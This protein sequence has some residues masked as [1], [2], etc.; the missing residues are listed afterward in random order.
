[1]LL[2]RV[3]RQWIRGRL[4]I[5]P[6]FK[7]IDLKWTFLNVSCHPF[8]STKFCQILRQTQKTAR[9]IV[10]QKTSVMSADSFYTHT[11]TKIRAGHLP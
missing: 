10:Y 5:T 4:T 1:M 11:S 7:E 2:I 8:S 9:S 6:L 3:Y